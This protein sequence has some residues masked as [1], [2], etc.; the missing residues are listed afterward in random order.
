MISGTEYSSEH[1]YNQLISDK[2]NT[3]IQGKKIISSNGA[4]TTGSPHSGEKRTQT[5]TSHHLQKLR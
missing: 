5:A 1:L 3:T 2:G 4:E